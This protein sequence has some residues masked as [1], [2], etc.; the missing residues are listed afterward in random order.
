MAL[1]K[2]SP[3]MKDWRECWRECHSPL[4]HQLVSLRTG[5]ISMSLRQLI[6]NR[7]SSPSCP[8]FCGAHHHCGGILGW[9]NSPFRISRV[10]YRNP[11]RSL[12]ATPICNT[13][14]PVMLVRSS[15]SV[16][17]V[18]LRSMNNASAPFSQTL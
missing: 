8:H 2:S 1:W 17:A 10:S 18:D 13:R 3:T 12:L 5:V 14:E 6:M 11:V 7:S 15:G 4:R 9:P 16:G